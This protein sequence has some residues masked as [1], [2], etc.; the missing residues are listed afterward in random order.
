MQ[1]NIQNPEYIGSKVAGQFFPVTLAKVHDSYLTEFFRY[2]VQ[3]WINDR[4]GGMEMQVKVDTARKLVEEIESGNAIPMKGSRSATIDP[5][6]KVAHALAT[7]A[8]KRLV[9]GRDGN[10]KAFTDLDTATRFEKVDLFI[11]NELTA[12][13]VDYLAMAERQLKEE[14]DAASRVDLSGLGI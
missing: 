1:L 5:V 3:R 4:T 12:N 11:A 6:T 10:A 2:G 8:I 14:D 9:S 13:K 7:K